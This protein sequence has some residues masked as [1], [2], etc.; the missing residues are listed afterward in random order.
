MK[1]F[2][3]IPFLLLLSCN[4]EDRQQSNPKNVH[5]P[6]SHEE[7]VKYF[8]ETRAFISANP[9]IERG[10]LPLIHEK[11]AGE[12]YDVIKLDF[13]RGDMY[14][15][16]YSVTNLRGKFIV[17]YKCQ[18]SE[19]FCSLG[20]FYRDNTDINKKWDRLVASLS[21]ETISKETDSY[22]IINI[23]MLIGGVY[24]KIHAIPDS[25]DHKAWYILNQMRAICLPEI[26]KDTIP[27]EVT[28]GC[29]CDVS[30][31][32]VTDRKK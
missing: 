3:L 2:P 21:D 28:N 18:A 6:T 30:R 1:I 9:S 7:L 8:E 24:R 29:I 31:K 11:E 27:N 12:M 10:E 22:I 23:E 19:K 26:P 15:H 25:P 14:G 4:L 17:S 5:Q 13:D 16:T 32:V 20:F